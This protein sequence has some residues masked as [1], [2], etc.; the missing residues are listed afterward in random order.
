MPPP[1]RC[2]CSRTPWQV[3]LNRACVRPVPSERQDC[4]R[5]VPY[6]LASPVRGG[7]RVTGGRGPW[8]QVIVFGI[9][10][11]GGEGDGSPRGATYSVIQPEASRHQRGV[12]EHAYHRPPSRAED[13]ASHVPA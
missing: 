10:R 2:L 4:V 11:G 13:M 12:L 5:Y 1:T 7:V 8:A 9:G 6:G 3:V